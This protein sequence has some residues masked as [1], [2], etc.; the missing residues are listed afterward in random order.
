ML[1]LH[2]VHTLLCCVLCL[3]AHTATRHKASTM[4]YASC[5]PLNSDTC[6]HRE[7]VTAG[8][9]YLALSLTPLLSLHIRPAPLGLGGGAEGAHMAGHA[10]SKGRDN[11]PLDAVPPLQ[12]RDD[13]ALAVLVGQADQLLSQPLK[14][15]LLDANVPA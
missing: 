10:A 14:L 11:A 7:S 13:P 8:Q 12:S 9:E 5:N 15:L 1:H 2:I 6:T 3:A 4:L